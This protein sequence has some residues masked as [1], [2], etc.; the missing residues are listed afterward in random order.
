MVSEMAFS[1]KQRFFPDAAASVSATTRAPLSAASSVADHCRME[2]HGRAVTQ[3][4]SRLAFTSPNVSNLFDR[5][6]IEHQLADVE[7]HEVWRVNN[8]AVWVPDRRRSIQ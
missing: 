4:I 2:H 6:W 7:G 5:D 1:R 8:T 3:G